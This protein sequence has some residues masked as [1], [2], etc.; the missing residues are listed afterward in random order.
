[1]YSQQ[2]EVGKDSKK[3]VREVIQEFRKIFPAVQVL[4]A[5]GSWVKIVRRMSGTMF[6]SAWT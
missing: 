6:R 3:D 4:S 1:M 2:E 5:A